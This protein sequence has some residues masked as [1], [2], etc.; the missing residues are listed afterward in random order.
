MGN[1]PEVLGNSVLGK[2][3]SFQ[4]GGRGGSPRLAQ[5]CTPVQ[6]T[7]L[8]GLSGVSPGQEG[9]EQK[10]GCPGGD[11]RIRMDYPWGGDCP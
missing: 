3:S 11:L 5:L 10:C 1:E 8:G 2:R 9:G 4:E 6:C 7:M